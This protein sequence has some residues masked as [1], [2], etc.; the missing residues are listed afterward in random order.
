VN[1]YAVLPIV[2]IYEALFPELNSTKIQEK[3]ALHAFTHV[4]VGT[5]KI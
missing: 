1:G 3:F 5:A 2:N 4:E